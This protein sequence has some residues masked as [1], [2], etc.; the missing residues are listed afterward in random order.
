I[1][2]AGADR[3]RHRPSRR[4]DHQLNPAL[5]TVAITQIRMPG[6]RGH[7][8]HQAKLAERKTSREAQRCLK[9]RPTIMSGAPG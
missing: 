3:A 4:G 8:Y 6:T 7:A 9:G 1:E 5:H 2:I